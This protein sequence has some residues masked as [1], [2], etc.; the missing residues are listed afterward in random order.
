MARPKKSLPKPLACS[1][2]NPIVPAKVAKPQYTVIRDTREQLGW[3]FL[4]RT[5][6]A[7]VI[8]QA[9]PTGD[10]SLVGCETKF[11]IERKRNTAEIA[12]NIYEDRFEREMERLSLFEMK[13][14]I[15]EFTLDDVFTFPKNSGIPYNKMRY[16][17]VRPAQILSKLQRIESVF[18]IHI[19]FGGNSAKY[20][21]SGLFKKAA[22]RYLWQNNV[23]LPP[24]PT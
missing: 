15:C 24:S 17:K 19:I 1:S 23:D 11:V 10:Y 13:Y 22:E 9:L 12:A 3:S 7:G 14:I 18:G 8:D 20:Y 2:D 6:C 16:I 21:A 4:A 5:P